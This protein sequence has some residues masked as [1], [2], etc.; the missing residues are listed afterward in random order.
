MTE[1]NTRVRAS[2][3]RSILPIDMESTNARV[4]G[5]IPSYNESEEKFEWV[6]NSGDGVTRS[7]W[8]QNG[9]ENLTDSILAWTDSTPDRT[10]SIQPTS[11]SF[12]YWIAGVKYTST[13]DTVQITDVEGVHYIYYDGDTLTVMVNPSF[14]DIVSSIETKALV[15]IVY[16]NATD[17][18]G[19][20]IGE[21]R[22][23]KSMSPFTHSYLHFTEGLR[24]INGIGL[25]T[26]SVDQDGDD[27]EDAQFGIDSG[28]VTDEDL[29]LAI[30][31]I[32]STTGLPI[33]YMTGATPIW[34]KT[35]N[36]GYSVIKTGESAEDRL[37]YNQ[38]TGGSWQ[39]TEV[40]NADFVLCH[41][42]ATTEK[43]KPMI[44]I[45]GQNIYTNKTQAR[46]GAKSEI[47]ELILNDILFPEIRPIATVIFQ[48]RDSYNNT[49]K[50]RVISTDEGDNYIDW[51][52]EAI[53]RVEI[54]TTNHNALTGLQGGTTDEYYHLNSSE[55]TELTQWIDNVTLGNDGSLDCGVIIST[56]AGSE[57][58]TANSHWTL[59]EYDATGMAL[60][61]V[62][63]LTPTGSV[64]ATTG[65]IQADAILQ[66]GISG[67]VSTTYI[68]SN[69]TLSKQCAIEYCWEDADDHLWIDC[70]LQIYD[71]DDLARACNFTI[72]E[73]DIET[74]PTFKLWGYLTNG[75][76]PHSISHQI[77]DTDD[78]YHIT[79][80]HANILGM[81]IDMPL[82]L[83]NGVAINEFS[84]DG[85]LAGDSDDAVP[86]EKA[87]KKYV[88]DNAGG[89]F[90]D[91]IE[92]GDSS[93]E[94]V[95]VSGEDASVRFKIDNTEQLRLVDGKLYPLTD[96]DIAIGDSTHR[97]KELHLMPSS[98][99]L[100]DTH[101]TEAE[102]KANRDN[103]VLNAFRIAINGS[104]SQFNMIDGVVDE[105]EDETGIDTGSST[106][107][108]Y[109]SD[110][111]YYSPTQTDGTITADTKLMM[112]MNGADDGTTFGDDSPS[113]HGNA[114]V[115]ADV[116]TKTGT[117]KWGTASAL[118][119][120]DSGYLYYADSADWDIC[121][122][123]SDNWTI[124][125]WIRF[126]DYTT[127]SGIQYIVGQTTNS[128]N[129][130]MLWKALGGELVFQARI[131]NVIE[132]S[133]AGGDL[134]TNGQWFH[135]AMCKVGQEYGVYIDG[136]QVAYDSQTDTLNVSSVLAIGVYKSSAG[137]L[138]N[139]YI[140]ELRIQHSNIFS[141][142]PNSTPDDTIVIPTKEYSD[143][144]VTNNMTL[145][146]ELTEAE[147]EP[148]EGRLVI[149]EEDV[150]AVTINTDLK[151][152]ISLD[153]GANWEQVTLTDEGDF[154]SSKRI[155]VGS[156]SLTDRDDKTMIYKIETL[157][158][159][160][161]K[162][163]AT[164]MGWR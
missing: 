162:I 10:L 63:M 95:D 107:E 35:I 123:N 118:F 3:I 74:N 81:S 15:S 38:Y 112:H 19:I 91:K 116:N 154:D 41:I 94:V 39:L 22:H 13:G 59:D 87:V 7:E 16:W 67:D 52:N 57:F 113:E 31:S 37:A 8:N 56:G 139:G 85:T 73:D 71:T 148:T 90:V 125:C 12:N 45:V 104:L 36:T 164:F 66:L 42:F 14:S 75:T 30:S 29:F 72:G 55:H 49:M 114:T 133:V 28:E 115:I 69:N 109:D 83:P 140:D 47:Q 161:L 53:S 6:E 143:V 145:V 105:Y 78:Y 86:T 27:N 21:E 117:K 92:E 18:E 23:G 34:N 136:V 33:Y 60:G 97:I 88:D 131:D 48:T 146:S 64:L 50:A 137:N 142:N 17:K 130:W 100:G 101:I 157:N 5:Y 76:A 160:E 141:A 11:T 121:A 25:N 89:G 20:Y 153:D 126:V 99:Y 96:D 98:L 151:A 70:S 102:Y 158:E 111:D 127:S 9:F 124:D 82:T 106:N 26:L 46:T 79:K 163:H 108:D 80:D 128:T 44:A 32:T 2:Q 51:R 149:L 103:I 24:Y 40:T 147:A 132:I 144:G 155:L 84:S 110:G 138:F 120:G 54:S 65:V 119:D 156:K 68:L 43:D 159:K 77:D 135:V 93:V 150:D 152:Y 134:R 1:R 62:P 58:G 61:Y 122:S 4:D 129:R